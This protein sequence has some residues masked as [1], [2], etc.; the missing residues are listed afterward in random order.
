MIEIA[1]AATEEK[2][3]LSPAEVAEVYVG[4]AAFW[5]KLAL[6][7]S[8][9]AYRVGSCLIGFRPADVEHFIANNPVRGP[10]SVRHGGRRGKK[11]GRPRQKR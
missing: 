7:K 3:L 11:T 8:L 5:R 1:D 10:C 9:P 2:R 4:T 6:N